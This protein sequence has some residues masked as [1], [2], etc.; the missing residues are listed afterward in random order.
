VSIFMVTMAVLIMN[1]SV[2]MV[3][4][5][6][7]IV[8]GSVLWLCL[9]FLVIRFYLYGDKGS[10]DGDQVRF[11]IGQ[12]MLVGIPRSFSGVGGSV[13]ERSGVGMNFRDPTFIFGSL[14]DRSGVGV[15]FRDPTLIFGSRRDRSGVGVT[16][17]E[18]A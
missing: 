14:R 18:S 12:V 16:V 10:L 1:G 9:F 17:R 7:S 5:S 13:R 3:T 11:P 8:A 6:V 15:N 4:M 2:S